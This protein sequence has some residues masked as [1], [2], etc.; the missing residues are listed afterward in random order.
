[1]NDH[2]HAVYAFLLEEFGGAFCLEA[3]GEKNSNLLSLFR[4]FLDKL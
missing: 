1:M 2:L 3:R 4:K